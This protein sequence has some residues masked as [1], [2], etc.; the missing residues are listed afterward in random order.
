MTFRLFIYEL[1]A[2]KCVCACGSDCIIICFVGTANERETGNMCKITYSN[3]YELQ[4]MTQKY[5]NEH[6][7]CCCYIVYKKCTQKFIYTLCRFSTN[8]YCLCWFNI[9]FNNSAVHR[10][11][12]LAAQLIQDNAVYFKF[13]III[14]Y[15][16]T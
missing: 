7:C 13:C 15:Y 12:T 9:L 16:Y 6:S 10:K 2:A 14:E 11:T 4:I 1:Y 3:T 5:S 8:T